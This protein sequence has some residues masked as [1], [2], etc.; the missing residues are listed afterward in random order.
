M[1][2]KRFFGS[3]RDLFECEESKRKVFEMFK[4]EYHE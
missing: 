1:A 3:N 4:E 2:P